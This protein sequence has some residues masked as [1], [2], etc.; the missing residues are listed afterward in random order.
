[1]STIKLAADGKVAVDPH[2]YW[3]PLDTC[4]VSAKVQLL[5]V[6]GVAVYGQYIK[7]QQGYLG[8]APLPKRPDWMSQ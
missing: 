3:Q 2:Y 8:W 5:T 6:G 4:P 7:G 1:M